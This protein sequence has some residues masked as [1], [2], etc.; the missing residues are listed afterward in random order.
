M[1]MQAP[2]WLQKTKG[3]LFILFVLSHAHIELALS[4]DSRAEKQ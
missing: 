4:G 3:I 2:K 1:G